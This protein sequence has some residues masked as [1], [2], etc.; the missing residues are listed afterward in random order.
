MA[1]NNVRLHS[2]APHVSASKTHIA[3][4]QYATLLLLCLCGTVDLSS[5]YPMALRSLRWFNKRSEVT[6]WMRPNSSLRHC[7]KFQI[8][9]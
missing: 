4:L 3:S 5:M 9:I 1:Y 2:G 6:H 7:A 8:A